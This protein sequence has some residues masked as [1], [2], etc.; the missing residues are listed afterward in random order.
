MA[1]MLGIDYGEKRIGLALSDPQEKLARRFLTLK[2]KG[3]S[4][5]IKELKKIIET[6]K[7]EKIVIGIPVGFSGESEQTR[8]VKN[9][10]SFIEKNINLPLETMNEVLTSRMAQEN[11]IK[12]GMK[13]IKEAL[14]QEAA[15]IILQ[16]YLGSKNHY[17]QE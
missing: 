2:N 8:T 12:A 6:E 16:D 11:L 5:T 13:N 1:V 7:V 4:S 15:R 3:C 10:I 9:F 17:K 14:D